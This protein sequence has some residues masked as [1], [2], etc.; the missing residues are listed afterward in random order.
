M[1]SVFFVFCL[2]AI[3]LTSSCS[4]TNT[5]EIGNA[6]TALETAGDVAYQSYVAVAGANTNQVAKVTQDYLIFKVAV[7]GAQTLLTTVGNP[8]QNISV[9]QQAKTNLDV[10]ISAAKAATK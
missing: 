3:A 8:S 10:S 5:Q 7:S 9:A 4:T 2:G 1:K 6:L